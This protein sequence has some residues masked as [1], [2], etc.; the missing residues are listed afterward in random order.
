MDNQFDFGETTTY[1]GQSKEDNLDNQDNEN[2]NQGWL[3]SPRSATP[4]SEYQV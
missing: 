1:Y 4:T 3:F 2:D